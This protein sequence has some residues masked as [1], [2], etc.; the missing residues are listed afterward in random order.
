MSVGCIDGGWLY[1][2]QDNSTIVLWEMLNTEQLNSI[3]LVFHLQ[4][5]VSEYY[6]G[7][8]ILKVAGWPDYLFQDNIIEL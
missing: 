5:Q 7:Q 1:M 6:N 8:G 4:I 3:F 2:V